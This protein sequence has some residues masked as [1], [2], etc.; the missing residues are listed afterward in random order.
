MSEEPVLKLEMLGTPELM[1][2]LNAI[3]AAFRGP[4]ANK[5]ISAWSKVMIEA[6]REEVPRGKTLN[7]LNSI[8][9]IR[10]SQRDGSL[11]MGAVGPRWM[12]VSTGNIAAIVIGGTVQRKTKTGANR[13]RMTPNPFV[14]RAAQKSGERARDVFLQSIA[15][16]LEAA[17]VSR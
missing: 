13:G 17:A 11:V 5:A 7:L 2:R 4:I 10:R 14:A 15:S 6:E 16:G 3:G 12:P 9:L 1:A 8:G